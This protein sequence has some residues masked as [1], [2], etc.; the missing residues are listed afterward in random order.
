MK[1]I[2]K[3]KRQVE[4]L[5][6]KATKKINTEPVPYWGGGD[7]QAQGL[8]YAYTKVLKLIEEIINEQN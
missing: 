8:E 1:K 2:S 7:W 6:E 4:E 5:Q 3:L